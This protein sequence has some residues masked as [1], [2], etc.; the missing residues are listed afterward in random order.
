MELRVNVVLLLLLAGVWAQQTA[1]SPSATFAAE[2]PGTAELARMEDAF[3][4]DSDDVVLARRLAETYLDLQRPGLAIAT[5]RSGDPALLE[6]PV[7]AHRLA[8]AYEQSGRV[9]DAL[10]TSDLALARCARSLGTSD[11]PSGTAVPRFSCDGH[12][13]AVLRMHREALRRMVE[14]GVARPATDPR[15]RLAYELAS[16]RARIALSR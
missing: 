12:Q 9:E 11:A 7:V 14:W 15:A 3:A 1:T 6:H 13:H 10:A 2:D 4:L 16:R 5:L 8:Q